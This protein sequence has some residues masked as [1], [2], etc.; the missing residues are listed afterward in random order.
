MNAIWLAPALAAPI[1]WA[2]SNLIDE[3]LV[4]DTQ[5]DAWALVLV[6]GA[7]TSLPALLVVAHPV[8]TT[9]TAAMAIAAGI[10]GVLVYFPY[11]KALL[12]E[13]ASTVTLMWN[14]SPVLIVALARLTIGER[15]SAA[16]YCAVAL[17]VASASLASFRWQRGAAWSTA[18]P[19]MSAASVLLA[20]SSVLEKAVYDRLPF[21]QGLS[22][23]SLGG[24]LATLVVAASAGRSRIELR[25]AF[26]Q[27]LGVLL[28]ANEGL[29]LAAICTLGLA[30]SLGP[31][32][33]VHA[34]GGLQ[35][36][37]VLLFR[38]TVKPTCL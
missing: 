37:F 8:P 20:I 38:A 2:I 33:I 1:L 25:H 19:W 30:T 36:L 22:W 27:R 12:F 24:L 11:F 5:L 13:S 6:T 15:L 14:L 18:L 4:G 10:T 3:H 29:D 21:V 23:I 31:V 35:P 26:R 17:L 28:V 7:F 9:T 34:V 16:S 32:S